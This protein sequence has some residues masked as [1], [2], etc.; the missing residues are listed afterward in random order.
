MAKATAEKAEKM[1][2]TFSTTANETFK[3]SYE[4]SVELMGEM[5]EFGKT[6]MEAVAESTRI[7]TKGFEELGSHAAAYTRDSF[8]KGVEAARS[9]T[10]A[11]SVQEAIELQTNFS[12]SAFETYLEQVNQMTGMFATLVRDA[13]APLNTQAGK[14]MSA[15]QK[16]A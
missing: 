10:G 4:R 14:F 2:E 7:T 11:K 3:K 13:S 6:N 15:M 8:E 12:K 1:F 16:S 9:M 5:G